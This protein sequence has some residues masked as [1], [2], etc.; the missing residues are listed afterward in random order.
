MLLDKILKRL[1]WSGWCDRIRV[2]SLNGVDKW[3]GDSSMG[4]VGGGWNH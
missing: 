2:Y 1:D 3:M 4:C